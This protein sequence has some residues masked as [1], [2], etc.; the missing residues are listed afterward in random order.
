MQ[1]ELIQLREDLL[2]AVQPMI[3]SDGLADEDRLTLVLRLAQVQQ[4]SALYRK[5]FELISAIGDSDVRLNRYL[6][7]LDEV[8]FVLNE[9]LK[10]VEADGQPSNEDAGQA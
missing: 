1:N 9:R 6:E 5:A 3:D 8:E 4:D 7:L 2:K 10:D